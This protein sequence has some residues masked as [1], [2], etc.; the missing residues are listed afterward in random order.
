MILEQKFI[1][2]MGPPK[3][4]LEATTPFFDDYG[5]RS[6]KRAIRAISESLDRH[7]KPHLIFVIGEPK[8]GKQHEL[9]DI[10][11]NLHKQQRSEGILQKIEREQGYPVP[12]DAV[13]WGNA[14]SVGKAKGRFPKH[15]LYGDFGG[16]LMN[17][18]TDEY[19][20][21]IALKERTNQAAIIA[22]KGVLLTGA[23]IDGRL[24]G[25]NRGLTAYE[26][27]LSKQG[28]FANLDYQS[29]MFGIVADPEAVACG[30]EL[31]TEAEKQIDNTPAL[32]QTLKHKG[33][34]II[35]PQ[36]EQT[37]LTQEQQEAVAQYIAESANSAA[38]KEIIALVNNLAI[39]LSSRGLL[40]LNGNPYRFRNS[41]YYLDEESHTWKF[42]LPTMR[43]LAV[44][45]VMRYIFEE[46]LGLKKRV[47]LG[48]THAL[49]ERILDL[50]VPIRN[51]ARARYPDIVNIRNK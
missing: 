38:S 21:L 51:F 50:G 42:H 1:P 31:R 36:G 30:N 47:F 39:G 14:F 11:A 33:E 32:V 23:R 27:I 15:L 48:K 16:E 35:T 19:E 9:L 22:A 20:Q 41:E 25:V 2:T 7:R 3:R 44:A 10:I 26:K 29:F 43:M 24:Y 34:I 12:V 49:D 17:W 37:E 46:N 40:R 28:P 5:Y 13:Y 8:N 45:L 4:V 6:P 18:V